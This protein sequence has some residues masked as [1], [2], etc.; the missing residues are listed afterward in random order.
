MEVWVQVPV[1]HVRVQM[2]QFAMQMLR[3]PR[4]ELAKCPGPHALQMDVW[5][6]RFVSVVRQRSARLHVAPALVQML[7]DHALPLLH[8]AL[9]RVPVQL[10]AMRVIPVQLI[11]T[12]SL[13]VQSPAPPCTA[14]T[15]ESRMSAR[16]V[17]PITRVVE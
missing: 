4:L 3:V 16:H 10:N 5:H 13:S 6:Q 12:A 9:S 2:L 11:M 14:S 17:Y 8:T 15:M 7:I 1:S